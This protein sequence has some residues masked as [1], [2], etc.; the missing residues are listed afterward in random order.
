LDRRKIEPP[1]LA[2]LFLAGL[3]ARN[4]HFFYKTIETNPDIPPDVWWAELNAIKAER[5]S[6]L[7]PSEDDQ[8]SGLAHPMQLQ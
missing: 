6:Y 7:Y 5:A 3:S 2:D 1:N 8:P 4:A